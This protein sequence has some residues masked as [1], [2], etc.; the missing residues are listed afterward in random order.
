MFERS[1][2]AA[3]NMK[4]LIAVA[5]VPALSVLALSLTPHPRDVDAYALYVVNN[6]SY[7]HV[8]ELDGEVF[9]TDGSAELVSRRSGSDLMLTAGQPVTVTYQGEPLTS[10]TRSETVSQLLE[11]LEIQPSPLEM[12]SVSFLDEA[13][14]ISVNSEFV[15]YEHITDTLAHETVYQYNSNK[16]AWEE[17][18]I[19][20]GSD[21]AYTEVYEVVYQDGEETARQLID[22]VTKAPVPTIIEKG[23]MENFANNGDAVA[24]INK[25]TDG[26]G[27]I[28]LDN[29]E[30]LTFSSARTMRGTAYTTGGSVGT[31]TASG[32]TVHVGVVAVDKSVIPL[33]TK[34]YV[35]SNDGQYDYGFAVAEDTGVR[36]NSIDL[37]MDTNSECIQFGVRECTVYILD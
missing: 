7:V 8:D 13:L 10:V 2:K 12:V 23:T 20:E 16:P 3:S 25:S 31:R 34:V 21:G 18:V 33:G 36:G 14:E 5:A 29:G 32:T 17:S 35:V 24:A 15:F 11:R 1:R 22:A 19:Q 4:R 27:T 26:S 6:D 28:T 9:L 30:T 37:Y